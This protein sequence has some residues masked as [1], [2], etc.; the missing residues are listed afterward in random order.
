MNRL[1]INDTLVIIFDNEYDTVKFRQS[2][3]G[4]QEIAI[5]DYDEHADWRLPK[6]YMGAITNILD[7][8]ASFWRRFSEYR[9]IAMK[10]KTRIV[11]DDTSQ[12]QEFKPF[13]SYAISYQLDSQPGVYKEPDRP[14]TWFDTKI[15][16][17]TRKIAYDT[18]LDRIRKA[19]IKEEHL[20]DLDYNLYILRIDGVYSGGIPDVSLEVEFQ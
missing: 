19:I 16:N 15:I 9:D 18:D 6:I 13:Y 3:V 1:T 8:M 7:V 11:K 4:M 20:S 5:R 12:K 17:T 2:L 14:R 10:D